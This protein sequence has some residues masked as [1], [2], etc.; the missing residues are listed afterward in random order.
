MTSYPCMWRGVKV[1]CC[2]SFC[3][4]YNGAPCSETDPN[5]PHYCG[6][7]TKREAPPAPVKVVEPTPLPVFEQTSYAPVRGRF[8]NEAPWTGPNEV[9]PWDYDVTVAIP[10]LDSSES[11]EAIV[12]LYRLQTNA[13]CYFVLIDTGSTEEQLKR[14]LSMQSVDCEVHSLRLN[15][16]RHP[17]D[18]PAIAMD[19][20]FS[21]CRTE[22]LLATHADCFPMR[23]NLVSEMLRICDEYRPVV[24]YE[25]TERPHSDWR[26]MVGHTLTMFHM[27]TMDRING[28]WSLR[29]LVA[30]YPHPDG[31]RADWTIS[32]ATSPNWP[33]TELLLNYQL[34][35]ANITPVIFGTEKNAQR[36]VDANI[37]HCR[38]WASA[39]LYS[40]GS[41][42][43]E[44]SSTWL[45][46]G[47]RKAEERAKEWSKVQ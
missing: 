23:A 42:Y 43:H 4:A 11:V 46:D 15:G 3:H 8:F 41:K 14:L 39:R 12:R 20:A 47:V 13:K 45:D 29:R 30:N 17:S 27:H 7:C 37:D 36:T 31:I 44:D 2:Y 40:A 33:D 1:D 5:A 26:G 35:A 21:S 34:R 19:L 16:V 28:Y 25:L 10:V 24:G 9:K 32:P 6:A 18:F 38:S 22:R